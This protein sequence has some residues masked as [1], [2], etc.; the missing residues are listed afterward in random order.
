[1]AN[2]DR[3][4]SPQLGF[5]FIGLG[6]AFL[7]MLPSFVAHPLVRIVAAADLR[8]EARSKLTNEFHA[9][10]YES[11]EE[12]CRDGEVNAVYIATPHRFHAEH[13]ITAARH[14]KHVIVEKPMALT[15]EDCQTVIQEVNRAGVKLIVGQTN[16]YDPPILKMGEIVR[17][18]ELGQLRMIHTFNYTEFL[19]R[20]RRPEELDTRQ[21]GGILFNQTPH[22]VDMVR[23]I[24][25]A[26]V[27]SVRAYAGAWDPTRPTEA[28]L[29][30]F[31]DFENGVVAT[32]VYSGYAHFNSDEFWGLAPNPE[33][34]GMARK[35]INA[36]GGRA[37]EA[38]LKRA[39]GYGGPKQRGW[40]A[41]NAARAVHEH[42]GI[43]IVSCDKGDL[44]ASA[45]GVIL[46]GDE[47]IRRLSVP[48]G[49]GGGR[50]A[51]VIDE[52]YDAV[53]LERP[54]VH[55][56]RWGMA[57]VEVCLALLQSSRERRE[58]FLPPHTRS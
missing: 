34:Y 25:G 20:P 14:G 4:D 6:S 31:L 10:T 23:L 11:V 56:G 52:L 13:A 21:G 37:E 38:A 8:Q 3:G 45:E 19:Y 27:R 30:A 24:G 54:L 33:T 12:L 5:G 18:G 57:T 43:M 42:F 28:G 35:A 9:K 44:R 15:L 40:G 53:V 1:M 16:S 36:V 50:R 2:S 17:S 47:N 46:Y 39:G 29:S 55:D 7:G 41:Q 22:Q 26:P 51:T 58:V 32:I 49:R 48:F